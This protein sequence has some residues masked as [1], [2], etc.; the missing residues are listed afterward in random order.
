MNA[1][2]EPASGGSSPSQPEPRPITAAEIPDVHK[3]PGNPDDAVVEVVH[4]VTDQEVP[5]EEEP[6]GIHE[7]VKTLLVGK[8]LSLDD[9]KIFSHISLIALFAWVGLGAD[10]LSSSCYGPEE[11]FKA[12]QQNGVDHTS[13]AFF[14]AIAT[15]FTVAV[16]SWCYIHIIS[17]FP[18]GG[19][20]YLV[21]SKMLGDRVGALSGC[22][23]VVD[24]ILTVTV[25]IAAAGDALFGLMPA[26]ENWGQ[27][28]IL[29]ET[30]AIVF[31]VVLNLRG[32]KESIYVL[33][34]IFLTFLICHA[35]LIAGV[36]GTHAGE[37]S[38][39]SKEIASSLH[40]SMNTLGLVGVMSL[41]L[42]AFAH[43]A[44]TYTGIEAVSNS[45]AVMREPRVAT[46]QRT[47]IYM[48]IS[49]AVTAGGLIMAYLLVGLKAE[50]DAPVPVAAAS[51]S[52]SA[53]AAVEAKDGKP[54]IGVKYKKTMNHRLTEKFVEV[55]PARIRLPFVIITIVSEALLLIVAAQA[56]FIGGPKCLANMAHDSWVPHWFGSLSERLASH[57]GILLIG[58][59]AAAALWSTGGKTSELVTMYSI[60][61][62]V[63]FTLSM[64]GMCFYWY[65]LRDKNPLWKRRLALFT[66]GAGLCG[67][68][69][70]I[71]VVFKFSE[72][73]WKTVIVTGL[74][75]GLSL[76]IR[77]Y[78]RNVTK[79]LKSLN[80]SLGTIQIKS[81]PTKAPLLPQEPTAAI[82]VGGYSG[83]G[84]HTLLNSLRFVPHH[85]KNIVFISVGVV[86]SGNF[87][88]AEAVDDLRKFTEDALEKY[89]D[90]ARRMGL[91]AK[92]YMTI[93]TDVVEELEQ[94][95][96]VVAKDFPR[97]TV[98]AG[99]LVFQ[100]ETWYGSILHNQ[101]AYSLQRRLQWD[102]IP[103]VI[104]PTRVKDA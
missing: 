31:L 24:Y 66:F 63:T 7:T 43:G 47:M 44:G 19:G 85:F 79:R 26:L 72:G 74:I 76:L 62:F 55:L 77:R 78:Y 15:V 10:G 99:Q 95:C 14:L 17:A 46:G 94:L 6:E 23:L 21:A 96:R 64:L 84:V 97:V 35:I 28:K 38:E 27:V 1:D 36:L 91:P 56:G 86:D 34:P 60:N 71:V 49:L 20:G 53:K 42:R 98:F 90:L 92:G 54:E 51:D 73:A 2:P 25:S 32:V 81:E 9:K 102:G 69:L 87:K 33:L 65:G 75:T 68:I 5:P 83:I 45:M 37:I 8:A 82:L 59:A 30:G 61:V 100:K 22:A 16:I 12:L 11:A 18:S 80:E 101:T 88:G 70:V 39:R 50:E 103:M 13:L 3:R 104:L 57:Y 67:T 48:A 93:G 89:V 52:G 41:F 40:S 4:E 58:A 29:V